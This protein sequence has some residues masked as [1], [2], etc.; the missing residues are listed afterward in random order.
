[1]TEPFA[2]VRSRAVPLLL[3]N[4]DTDVITPMRRITGASGGRGLAYYAFE[5]LRYQGGDGDL[6]E[7]DPGFPLNDPAFA[8]AQIMLTGTNFG[9]GSSRETAPVAI[10]MLGFRVLVGPSFGDIFYANCFQQGLLPIVLPADVVAGL[11]A[12]D[13]ELLV[14]L[15]H[16]TITPAGGAAATVPFEVNA[17]RK[18]CLL[19]GLDL[20]GLALAHRDDIDRYQ[21]QARRDRP[22]LYTVDAGR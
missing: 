18:T 4:I 10:A 13:G 12:H 11:A 9:S 14:D 21:Q 7:P 5:S 16:Q 6:G 2:P 19:E 17:L 22:W 15:E 20:V 8:G 1:M 3:P